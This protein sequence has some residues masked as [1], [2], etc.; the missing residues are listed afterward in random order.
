MNQSFISKRVPSHFMNLNL[1]QTKQVP[2]KETEKR[3]NTYKNRTDSWKKLLKEIFG[4][5]FSTLNI[6]SDVAQAPSIDLDRKN[7]A[8]VL[9]V[10]IRCLGSQ[11]LEMDAM[12]GRNGWMKIFFD[13]YLLFYY[14]VL[15]LTIYS[16]Y[17]SICY[18][19]HFFEFISIIM[20][21]NIFG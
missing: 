14:I 13:W 21:V 11:L 16:L 12:F 7:S 4:E 17:S 10:Q 9:Q 18:Y 2:K 6:I 15:C 19:Y 5:I 1:F 3:T 8:G 20:M